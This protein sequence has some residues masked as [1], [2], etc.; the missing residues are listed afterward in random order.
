M[1]TEA[2]IKSAMR[3]LPKNTLD[4]FY[5]EDFAQISQTGQRSRSY[6]TQVFSML[7]CTQEALSPE[8][9]IQGLA[10]TT[11]QQGEEVN[12]FKMIDIC[13]N[14]VVLDS[15]L[16]VLRFAHM[17]FQEF[18]ETRAEFAP[19]NVHSV[20]ATMCLDSC[21]QGLPK[22]MEMELSP[23]NNFDHYS[24]VYWAEH[25]RCANVSGNEDIIRRKMQ[26]FVFDGGDIA[27]SFVD[28]IQAVNKFA[29][30]LPDDH[31]LAKWLDSVINSR[32]S[33]L[34]TACVFGLTPVIDELAQVTEYDWNQTNDL[35]QSGLYL[36][37]AAG[38]TTIVQRLLQH[39][40]FVNPFGGNLDHPLHAACFRGHAS[41]VAL[42]LDHGADPKAGTRSALKYALLGDH[43]NI[44]L[45]Y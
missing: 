2:D 45:L 34:F 43:E 13:S 4:E 28:W 31:T 16:N 42:L 19:H 18:L 38:R 35:G 44:A 8:T 39:E 11:S 17:S 9:L 14:L 6:A 24:A 37:A 7:L 15:E 20:A 23:K 21:L 3:A 33:P 36:A 25:C 41:I 1:T 30:R 10:K 29:E 32:D 40:V 26:E 5:E 12:I 22:E 27:L